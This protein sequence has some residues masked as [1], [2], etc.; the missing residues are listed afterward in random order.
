[1]AR[2]ACT[3]MLRNEPALVGAFLRYHADLFGAENLFVIDNGS[4]DLTT[5]ACLSAFEAEGANIDRS[6]P[7]Q[8]DYTQKGRIIGDLVK[9]LDQH[10]DYDFY[11]LLDCDEFVVLKSEKGYTCRKSSIHQ[12]LD[13]MRG[14]ERILRVGLNLSNILGKSFEF[15]EFDY[16][17]TIFPKNVLAETDHGHH[18]GASRTGKGSFLCDIVYVHYHYRPYHE[19]VWYARQK[20]ITE[21]T[22][23]VLDD[24][25]KLR[26]F[27]GAGW[28]MLGYLLG[29]SDAYYEQFR[30]VESPIF[31]PELRKT[32]A[33]LDIKIS[34]NEFHLPM[35]GGNGQKHRP[36]FVVV[37]NASIGSVEGWAIDTG[38]PDAPL[39]LK[40]LVDGAVAYEGRCDHHRPDVLASGLEAEQ[41]GFAF[42]LPQQLCDGRRHVLT[43]QKSDGTPMKMFVGG[44]ERLEADLFTDGAT[45]VV[46]QSITFGYVDSFKDGYV[47]GWALRSVVLPDGVR[48]LGQT[49]VALLHNRKVVMQASAVLGRPDVAQ[50]MRGE[51]KCGFSFQIPITLLKNRSENIFNVVLTPE[52]HDLEGSPFKILFE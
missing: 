31:F 14:E 1:M 29:G 35:R 39:C 20:L 40:F 18:G 19:V 42:N 21:V 8:E 43:V 13:T 48:L 15:R 6:F 17:K 7:T 49:T 44:V 22:A 41:V 37:E 23:E 45:A 51:T 32:F 27:K 24:V 16:S 33:E 11:F 30:N 38:R 26:S 10:N 4:T 50:T 46:K 12:Y 3:V 25:L 2:V 52:M 28:H 47:R 34:F 9:R 5:L 36:E